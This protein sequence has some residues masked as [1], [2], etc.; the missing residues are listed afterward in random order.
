MQNFKLGWVVLS[1]FFIGPSGLWADEGKW[2]QWRG[3]LGTGVSL[4]KR[5]PINWSATENVRW[6]TPLPGRGHSTPVIWDNQIYLTTAVPVG[7]KLTPKMSGRPGAHDNLPVD[8]KFQFIVIALNADDGTVN[9]STIVHEAVPV[10][11]AHKSASLASGSPVTDGEYVYA[12]FGSH[13]LY[14]LD[15]QGQVIW[16]KSFGQMHSKHGHGEGSSPA[17]HGNTLVINWDHEEQSF[18]VALNKKNGSELWRRSR[19]EVTSWS[20]PI[21][22]E[23]ENQLQAIVCGTSRVRGYDLATGEIVWECGGLSANIV[24]TPVY[25][26]GLLIV[27][28]SYEIRSLMALDIR[29]AR[30]DITDSE[31]VLWSRSRGTPYVPSMLLLNDGVYFLAHYQN[32][33]TRAN[34]Q[35]G[36]DE[37]GPMRLGYLASIYASPIAAGGNVYVTDL[38]G[39]TM[40]VSG[41]ATPRVLSVNRLGEKVNASLAV[42]DERLLI[43]GEKY[44]YCIED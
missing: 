2:A 25:S 19:Q 41:E 24:A 43:R 40:V 42:F 35:T 28:S 33:L 1:L 37:P 34:V 31:R 10:E 21:V 13:G 9:W 29:G 22:A 20:T 32:I 36:I 27:G 3:P 12:F 8:S 26:N 38:E 39:T 5:A 17:L 14:C 18:I 23:V 4:D 16:K 11:G 6:R 44:L 15:R 30:G 7:E